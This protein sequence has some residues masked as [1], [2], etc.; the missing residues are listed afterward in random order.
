MASKPL[1]V[2]CTT[3]TVSLVGIKT[4]LATHREGRLNGQRHFSPRELP[5]VAG[6]MFGPTLMLMAVPFH[7]PFLL[8]GKTEDSSL[9]LS[10]SMSEADRIIFLSLQ[11]KKRLRE[12]IFSRS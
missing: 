11:M 4:L 1:Q 2:S 7:Q 3:F 8:S 9:S 6:N 5:I 12:V 10:S